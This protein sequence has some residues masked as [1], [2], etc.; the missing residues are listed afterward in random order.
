MR[1]ME[2]AL[3][4]YAYLS[5]ILAQNDSHQVTTSVLLRK[6]NKSL[7]LSVIKRMH[8]IIVLHASLR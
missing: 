5:G 3:A 7:P 8:N 2:T 4:S 6:R 1:G